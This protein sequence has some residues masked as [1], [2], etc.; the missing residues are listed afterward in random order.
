MRQASTGWLLREPSPGDGP[1]LFAFPFA[2]SG[3]SS[4]RRWPGRIGDIEVLPV[5]LPGREFRIK[6]EPYRTFDAFAR[7]AVA[8]LEPFLGRPYAVIGHCMGA[9]LAHA[10]TER[11]QEV[12][13][14][15]ARL[16]TS[17][18]L[19]PS[20][21][22]YGYY[23]PWMSER[24]IAG[25]L[26]RVADELGDGPIPDELLPLS[27]RVL[28]ADVRMCLDHAPPAKELEV[29]ISAIGWDEDVDVSPADLAEWQGYGETREYVLHGDPLTFL[30]APRGLTDIIEDDFDF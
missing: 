20:R 13:A 27:V 22:F 23:H 14:P 25:E 12:G 17:A 6:E 16:F 1:V 18:S 21:G 30:T 10:F 24:R 28:R 5:Q 8:A 11:A 19:V 4:L 26:R 3:A 7:D 15:P 2:G 29:P 9:L